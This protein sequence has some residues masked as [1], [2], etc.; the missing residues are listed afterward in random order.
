ML[1][2]LYSFNYDHIGSRAP[3]SDAGGCMV[4]GPRWQ[5]DKAE[6]TN[7]LCRSETDFSVIIG[8][9]Q[10]FTPAHM[11]HVKKNQADYTVQPLSAFLKQPA[12][13]AAPAIDF[14][15][16]VGDDPFNTELPAYPDVRLQFTPPRPI[17]LVMRL[18]WPKDTPPSILPAG[19]G[20][21]RPPGLARVQ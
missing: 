19:A 15:E 17:Y 4:A 12:P 18:Y 9:T 14:P 10:W 3:G 1:V 11:V 2:D 6:G 5:G 16:F 7:K 8:G 21:W 20:T 13:P